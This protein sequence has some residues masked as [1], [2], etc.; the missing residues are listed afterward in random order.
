[1][2]KLKIIIIF[3]DISCRVVINLKVNTSIAVISIYS[4]VELAFDAVFI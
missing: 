4:L 3:D 1:M 2:E